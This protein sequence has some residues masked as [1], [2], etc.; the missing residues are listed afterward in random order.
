MPA[1]PRRD[2]PPPG[3][4]DELVARVPEATQKSLHDLLRAKFTR[5]RRLREEELR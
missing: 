5:V 3:R 2:E 1:A 4:L